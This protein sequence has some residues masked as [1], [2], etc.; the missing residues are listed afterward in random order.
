[1]DFCHHAPIT[2]SNRPLAMSRLMLGITAILRATGMRRRKRSESHLESASYRRYRPP[3]GRHHGAHLDAPHR[4][5]HALPM[6]LAREGCRG[7]GR[8]GTRTHKPRVPVKTLH[9]E[10]LPVVR[11]VASTATLPDGGTRVGKS[12]PPPM[13]LFAVS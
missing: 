9:E 13:I 10:G 8:V 2:R 3:G 12:D 7:F 6:M 4:D 5:H 1:V 11:M